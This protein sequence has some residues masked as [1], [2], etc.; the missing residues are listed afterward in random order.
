M[1]MSFDM[2]TTYDMGKRL[3]SASLGFYHILHLPGYSKHMTL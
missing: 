3:T 1:K 2:D